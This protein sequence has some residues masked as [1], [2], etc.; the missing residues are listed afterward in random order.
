MPRYRMIIHGRNFHVMVDGRYERIGFHTPRYAD[1]PDPVAAVRAALD[2]FR[3]SQKYLTMMRAA[4]N[5]RTDQAILCAE[6]VQEAAPDARFET[7]V[8]GLVFYR[9]ADGARSAAVASGFPPRKVG[10]AE[11]AGNTHA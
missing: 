7:G 6:E 8:P 10:P 2:A 3:W 1:G 4:L 11:Q 5:S 9:E